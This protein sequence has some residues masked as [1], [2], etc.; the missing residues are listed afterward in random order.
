MC[1]MS[2]IGSTLVLLLAVDFLA[3]ALQEKET[4]PTAPQIRASAERSLSFLLKGD[5][6][7]KS[8]VAWRL[9]C[10]RLV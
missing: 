8:F 4:Q 5:E 6:D 10:R 9:Y 7:N 3:V 2:L 1:P